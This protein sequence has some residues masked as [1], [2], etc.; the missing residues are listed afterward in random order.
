MYILTAD[1]STDLY[2]LDVCI[3]GIFDNEEEAQAAA[4]SVV[5]DCCSTY[6]IEIKEKGLM[7]P[8]DWINVAWYAE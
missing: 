4:L 1:I 8:Q 3:L 5:E 6:V 7:K 2:E